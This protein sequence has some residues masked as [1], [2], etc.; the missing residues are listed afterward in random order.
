MMVLET[1]L[2]EFV[3][4]YS[5]LSMCKVNARQC[6]IGGRS[7]YRKPGDDRTRNL[8]LDQL[9]GQ[10]AHAAASVVLFGSTKAY[11]TSRYFA[12]LFPMVGD[13]PSD[14]P[15]G[16][17]DIKGTRL[18]DGLDRLNH[19]LVVWPRDHRPNF[20]YMLVIVDIRE[21]MPVKCWLAGW[22]GT[23]HLKAYMRGT[24]HQ[25]S[26]AYAMQVRD[27]YPVPPFRWDLGL[28]PSGSN[29]NFGDGRVVPVA[30]SAPDSL[31][32]QPATNGS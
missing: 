29:Q 11:R 22:A 12:N 13:G 14:I 5:L 2:V 4:P 10:I 23:E 26:G 18:A 31:F 30:A 6:M 15:L 32:P 19:H 16:N 8:Y 17:I 1:D 21:G 24:G 20:V 25:F 7:N 28:Q 27:L 3:V 9:V